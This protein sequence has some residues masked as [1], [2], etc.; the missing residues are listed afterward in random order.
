MRLVRFSKRIDNSFF[1]LN[2]EA[3][4]QKP[5]IGQ[6]PDLVAFSQNA[7]FTIEAKGR[8]ANNPGKMAKH[9]I[10]AGSGT[11]KRSYSVASVSYNLYNRVLCNYHD[12]INDEIKYDSEGLRKSS[13]IFY[14]NLLEFR[15]ADYFEV[16]KVD[17]Q[18]EVFYEVDFSTEKF[19]KNIE[20]FDNNSYFNHWYR[21]FLSYYRPKLILPGN[22]ENL[23]K[24]G[25]K[26]DTKPFIFDDKEN[27]VYIDRDRIGLSIRK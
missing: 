11:L 24:N 22:I 15:N 12:P 14:S 4:A 20:D 9:K 17:Y 1:T 27:K 5:L 23:S 19:F 26:R 8:K 18:N 2:Y 3:V 10:Q 25:L 21:D 7:V 13:A 6:R 16:N